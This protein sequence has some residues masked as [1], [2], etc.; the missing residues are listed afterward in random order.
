MALIDDY[1]AAGIYDPVS[2]I[3]PRRLRLLKWLSE[4]GFTVEQMREANDE[5]GLARMATDRYLRGD[6]IAHDEAL[7][8]AGVD[9]ATWHDLWIAAGLAPADTVSTSAAELF[10]VFASARSMFS[11]DAALHFLRVIGSSVSRI[12]EAA[13][14]LFMVDVEGPMVAHDYEPVELAQEMF[15]AVA[16]LDQIDKPIAQLLRLHLQDSIQRYRTARMNAAGSMDTP[17]AIGF[18]DL[19]GFTP[20]SR[21]ANPRELMQLVVEFEGQANDI[22]AA[23]GGRVV[24][25]IGDEVMFTT[26]DPVA[27]AEIVMSLYED[28]REHTE[29]TPRGGLAYGPVLAHG[30]DFYGSTVNLASRVADVAVP[31][32]VLVTDNFAAQ[33]HDRFAVVPAGRRMLRGFDEPVTLHTLTMSNPA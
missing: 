13:N 9:E 11:P 30:G 26:V 22:V 27:S 6:V 1:I 5:D 12:A 3:A 28:I 24:K 17:M 7:R 15:R 19:V 10:G 23:H 21:E 25:F 16:L 18:V 32:E 2:E 29:V 20:L 4:Q 31:W 8:I 33:L 14:A